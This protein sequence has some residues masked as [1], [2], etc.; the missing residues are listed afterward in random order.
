MMNQEGQKVGSMFLDK[1]VQVRFNN[2]KPRQQRIIL[3]LLNKIRICE[4]SEDPRSGCSKCIRTHTRAIELFMR[5]E[6]INHVATINPPGYDDNGFSDPT[7][8][9]GFD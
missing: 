3:N 9:G 5:F 7:M 1:K 8:T 4:G 2:L 6:K